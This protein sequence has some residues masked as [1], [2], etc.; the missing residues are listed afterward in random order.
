MAA[1]ANSLV[2]DCRTVC[3]G[4]TGLK[5]RKSDCDSLELCE[6]EVALT[7]AALVAGRTTL[8]SVVTVL[9]LPGV[10]EQAADTAM[11]WLES[12]LVFRWLPLYKC[13]LLPEC[14]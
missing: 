1:A 5:V 12:R 13:M 8:E 10:S 4:L 9:W 3:P 7:E 6:A 2:P 11:D 14:C